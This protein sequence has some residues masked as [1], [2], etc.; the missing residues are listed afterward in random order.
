MRPAQNVSHTVYF[1]PQ[2]GEEASTR[3][4]DIVSPL[5]QP[6]PRGWSPSEAALLPR[7]ESEWGRDRQD[8]VPADADGV[9]RAGFS[10]PLKP[11]QTWQVSSAG[12]NSNSTLQIRK[13][14]FSRIS[15]DLE[16]DFGDPWGT[17]RALNAI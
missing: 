14:S 6:Q 4:S 13:T 12:V 16:Q 1:R 2:Y 15:P 5:P 9:L 11:P 7:G 17:G 10:L 3:T 8:C